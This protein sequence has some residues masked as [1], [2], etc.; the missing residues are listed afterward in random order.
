V[1]GISSGPDGVAD[2]QAMA[3]ATG[4]LAPEGGVDCDGNGTVDIPA[5]EPLVC[6]IAASGEGIGEAI[7]GLV[8]AA[9]EARRPVARCKDVSTTTDPGECSAVVSV[10]DGS[11]DP[12]GGPV[13]VT[14]SPPGPYPVGTTAVTLKV[15]DE[16]GLTDFCVASVTVVDDEPPVPVCNAP[17]T[18]VPPDVPIAFTVTATDNCA[19]TAVITDSDCFKFTK[20]GKRVDKTR[21]CEVMV[22]GDRI[23][24]TDSGGVGDIISWTTLATDVNG[25]VADGAC[26]VTVANPGK[27]P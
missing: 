10:D 6:S 4:A 26:Q 25:N 2:L 20:K 1:I 15:T 9:I 7:V 24:I 13:T 16:T 14:Q 5:G 18:I 22:S 12:D 8:T 23:T 3:V 17:A 19:A 27:K 21:S 11:S